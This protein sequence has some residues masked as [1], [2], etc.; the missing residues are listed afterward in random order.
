M[1]PQGEMGPQGPAGPQGIPG[2][3]GP[4]GED[5]FGYEQVFIATKTNSAPAIPSESVKEVD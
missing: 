1:G 5:G 2:E 3:Q 4:Q